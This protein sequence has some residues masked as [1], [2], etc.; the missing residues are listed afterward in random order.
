MCLPEEERLG[1]SDDAGAPSIGGEPLCGPETLRK[2]PGLASVVRVRDRSSVRTVAE[3]SSRL[4][5]MA[6]RRDEPLV[7]PMNVEPDNCT[8]C[9][10]IVNV[11]CVKFSTF[12][13][14]FI[15]DLF[16]LV[17]QIRCHLTTACLFWVSEYTFW[18]AQELILL[19]FV[20]IPVSTC[21]AK[22][23]L[24]ITSLEEVSPPRGVFC[25]EVTLL[26]LLTTGCGTRLL[27]RSAA[28]HPLTLPS[29]APVI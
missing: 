7:L 8:A 22:E 27:V 24:T 16:E 1:G 14:H 2:V 11:V 12:F 26:V 10:L 19:E 5:E 20:D 28:D 6:A 25:L 17:L 18:E 29:S 4:P 15:G 21:A 3:E 13:S 23:T 9:V